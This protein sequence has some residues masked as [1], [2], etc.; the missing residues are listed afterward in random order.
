[1]LKRMAM[2]GRRDGT[3]FEYFDQWWLERHGELVKQ[4]AGVHRYHQNPVRKEINVG[5]DAP[6]FRFDG[7]VELWFETEDDIRACYE[8]PTGSQC[9]I[10]ETRFLGHNTMHDVEDETQADTSAKLLVILSCTSNFDAFR[11]LSADWSETLSRT[12]GAR[13]RFVRNNV[14]GVRRRPNLDSE[15]VPA[16]QFLQ[17]QFGDVDEASDA[18]AQPAVQAILADGLQRFEKAGAYIVEERRLV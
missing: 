1:M 12:L 4:A 5:H 3:S 10:D 2:L 16:A 8:S 6:A 9:P 13:R 18:T 11:Q 17:F 14:I 15:P 7:L